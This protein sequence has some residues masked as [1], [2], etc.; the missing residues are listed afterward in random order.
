MSDHLV[1]G[2]VGIIIALLGI[3][4]GRLWSDKR[5]DGLRTDIKKVKNEVLSVHER[6]HIACKEARM[7]K[8]KELENILQKEIKPRL[9]VGNLIMLELCERA[10]VPKE[11]L[12]E[13]RRAIFNNTTVRPKA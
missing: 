3:G 9:T 1:L 5:M 2:L 6:C 13:F 10:G 7:A 11:K 8:E 12:E 4:G